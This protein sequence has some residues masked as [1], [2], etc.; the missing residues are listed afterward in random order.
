VP[1]HNSGAWCRASAVHNAQYIDYDICVHSNQPNQSATA[2][3]SNGE[4][5]SY[6]TDSSGYADIYLYASPGDAVTVTVG[7]A[8]CSTAA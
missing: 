2:T 7:A 5:P 4:P 8:S 3:A 6:Y 1:K